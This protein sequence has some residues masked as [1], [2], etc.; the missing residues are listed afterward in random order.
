MIVTILQ[1]KLSNLVVNQLA[2]SRSVFCNVMSGCA[3]CSTM[4]RRTEREEICSLHIYIK[5][6]HVHSIIIE[7]KKV[8]IKMMKK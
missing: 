4:T 7:D 2:A 8:V 5:E 6:I 1:K 3:T